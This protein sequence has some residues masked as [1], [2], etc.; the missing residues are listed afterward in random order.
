MRAPRHGSRSTQRRRQEGQEHRAP[1]EA[2]A[3]SQPAPPA[4]RGRKQQ[5]ERRAEEVPQ[6]QE[7]CEQWAGT[8]EEQQEG[9]EGS[10]RRAPQHPAGSR[11]P[12]AAAPAIAAAREF[13]S[14][15][16]PVAAAAPMDQAAGLPELLEAAVGIPAAAASGL[17]PQL[18]ASFLALLGTLPPGRQ[19]AK[20]RGAGACLGR[21]AGTELPTSRRL[22]IPSQ[23]IQAPGEFWAS[24]GSAPP[25]EPS[26]ANKTLLPCRPAF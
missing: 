11:A 3:L 16:Q 1:G 14:A 17:T 21:P 9:P 18:A 25:I 26:G 10:G 5:E 15:A 7:H 2:A 12:A 23:F 20:V 24:L 22:H 6:Q 19:A 13:S 8:Q 4:K